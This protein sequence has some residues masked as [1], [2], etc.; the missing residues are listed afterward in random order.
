MP[1]QS[2]MAY[3]CEAA[4]RS[5][6]QDHCPSAMYGPTDTSLRKQDQ[7][8]TF[9]QYNSKMRLSSNYRY[10]VKELRHSS[11]QTCQTLSWCSIVWP[12]SLGTW[13]PQ[14]SATCL[15]LSFL[16]QSTFLHYPDLSKG[17][18]S[19]ACLWSLLHN[20][21]LFLPLSSLT[22]STFLHWLIEVCSYFTL[23]WEWECTADLRQSL[24]RIL[25]ATCPFNLLADAEVV[26]I[27][28]M[29]LFCSFISI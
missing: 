16:Q 29:R 18:F 10:R 22:P 1:A 13:P 26:Q 3:I 2:D 21:A 11:S 9:T 25:R 7:M 27:V 15:H 14:H 17:L 23:R 28:D 5:A 8:E 24:R 12:F 4:G 19:S 20:A 6:C